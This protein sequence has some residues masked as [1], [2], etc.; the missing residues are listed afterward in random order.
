LENEKIGKI[1]ENRK[2]YEKIEIHMQKY[3]IIITNK[4]K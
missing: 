4:N 2:T 1:G 3:K